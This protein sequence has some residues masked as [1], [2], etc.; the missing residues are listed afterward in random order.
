MPNEIDVR[1]ERVTKLFGDVAAVDDLSLDI[2]E[3]E[4]FSMLGPVGLRE[5]HHAPHD[6]RVRGPD[7]TARSTSGVAT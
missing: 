3:G 6:R 4:F 5:D 2:E 7:A 1:L